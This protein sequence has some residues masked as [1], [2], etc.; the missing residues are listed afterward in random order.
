MIYAEAGKRFMCR[1]GYQE[2]FDQDKY[3]CLE[4]PPHK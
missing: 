3:T 4:I 2:I 1:K